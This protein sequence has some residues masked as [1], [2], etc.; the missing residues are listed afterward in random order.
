[1]QPGDG[2]APFGVV[3]LETVVTGVYFCTTCKENFT[4]LEAFDRHR[5]GTHEFTFQEGLRLDSP[6]E[7]G[8]RCLDEEEM[9]AR[10]WAKSV[11]GGWFDPARSPASRLRPCAAPPGAS[12]AAA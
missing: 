2:R 9:R 5:V 10:G 3:F 4:G 8:R 6:R 11:R 1:M 7:D 12:V